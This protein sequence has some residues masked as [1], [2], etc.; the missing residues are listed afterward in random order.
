MSALRVLSV[1]L[2][3]LAV[4][5]CAPQKRTERIAGIDEGG[6]YTSNDHF[7]TALPSDEGGGGGFGGGSVNLGS[8]P[9]PSRG[10]SR[11]LFPVSGP[12]GSPGAAAGLAG[13]AAHNALGVSGGTKGVGIRVF[14]SANQRVSVGAG[15]S[16]NLKGANAGG[17]HVAVKF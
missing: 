14:Q 15:F 4:A 3:L 2:V 12:A 6:S 9:S 11:P 17:L 13:S 1:L 8:F 16:S 7:L 10:G 5:V